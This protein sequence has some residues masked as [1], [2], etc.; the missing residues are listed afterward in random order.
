MPTRPAIAT[1][2]PLTRLRDGSAWRICLEF[3]EYSAWA[4]YA[5]HWPRRLCAGLAL[6]YKR[7]G[8]F[9]IQD[10]ELLRS[11]HWLHFTWTHPGGE[12]WEFVPNEA[13]RNATRRR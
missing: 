7:L 8:W 4:D 11:G 9:L 10:G 12:H 3:T 13:K 1:S 5:R 6:P 2:A